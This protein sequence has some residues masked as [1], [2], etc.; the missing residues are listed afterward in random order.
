MTS[1]QDQPNQKPRLLGHTPLRGPLLLYQDLPREG[2]W[3]LA[4]ARDGQVLRCIGFVRAGL[5]VGASL[6]QGEPG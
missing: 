1:L 2:L 5:L 3:Y 6:H 4:R